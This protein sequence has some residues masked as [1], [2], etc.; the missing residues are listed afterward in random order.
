MARTIIVYQTYLLNHLKI[1]LKS[2][3][4]K[5]GGTAEIKIKVNRVNF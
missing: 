4:I 2:F 5:P 1:I 3:K